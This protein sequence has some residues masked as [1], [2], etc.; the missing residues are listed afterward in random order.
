MAIGVCQDNLSSFEPGVAHI[1]YMT[2]EPAPPAQWPKRFGLLDDTERAVASRLV[3]EVDR[4]QY[5][6]HVLARTML[7]RFAGIA[8]SD[9]RFLPGPHGK[10]GIHPAL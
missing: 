6:A 8:P 2:L 9:L 7:S 1:W 3:R 5:V 4:R 10:P